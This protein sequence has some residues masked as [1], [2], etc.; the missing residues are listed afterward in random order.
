VTTFVTALLAVS[1][2]ALRAG[3]AEHAP[4]RA[5]G[6]IR[7]LG[8]GERG[9][10]L[11]HLLRLGSEDRH[12]RF[13]GHAGDECV[14][15]YCAG[16][17]WSRSVVLGCLVAGELRAAGELK[18]IDRARPRMAEIAVS[19]EVQFRGRGIG[20]ELCRRLAVR[21]RNRFVEKVHMLCPLDNRC[22]QRIARRLGGALAFYPGE[23][24][25]EIGLPWPEPLSMAEEWLDEA[26]ALPWLRP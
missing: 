26:P 17:D 16:L 5:G 7:R 8:R 24:E 10:L 15:A 2:V 3:A 25:A 23:V 18:L 13:G 4:D 1:P 6:V 19:V 21:A 12:L 22:V 20:T 9:R 11:E 14:R